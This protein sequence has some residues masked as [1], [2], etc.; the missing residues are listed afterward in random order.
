MKTVFGYS[1]D[2]RSAGPW[3]SKPWA[4]TRSYPCA[5]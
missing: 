4:K 3:N 2:T 5:A 1:A